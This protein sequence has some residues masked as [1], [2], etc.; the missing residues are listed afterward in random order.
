MNSAVK[1]SRLHMWKAG[2]NTL[3]SLA[4]E[5]GMYRDDYEKYGRLAMKAF[6]TNQTCG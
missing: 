5:M 1:V 4:G 2:Q 3:P 6:L